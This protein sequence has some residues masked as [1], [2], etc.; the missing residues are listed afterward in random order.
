MLLHHPGKGSP[1]Y[2]FKKI[3]LHLVDFGKNGGKGDGVLS[4]DK[5]MGSGLQQREVTFHTDLQMFRWEALEPTMVNGGRRDGG[6]SHR[7]N[8]FGLN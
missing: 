1:V 6:L 8:L 5:L 3:L 2:G 7:V 4:V